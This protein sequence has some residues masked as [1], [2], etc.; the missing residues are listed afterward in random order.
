M[1]SNNVYSNAKVVNNNNGND[2]VEKYELGTFINNNTP[3]PVLDDREINGKTDPLLIE[4]RKLSTQLSALTNKVTNIEND[5]ISG[6]DIDAQVV[7]AIKDL[8]HYAAFFEQATFQ[9]EAKLLKTS[10]SIAQKIISIEVGENS[11]NMAKQTITHLLEKIKTASKVQIHLN[12]KDY[13]ILKDQLNLES[14]IELR[15]DANVSAGG[16]VIASD[17]GNFDGNIEAKVAS[18]LENLDMVI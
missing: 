14:F 9:M 12:P 4:I 17:L 2:N 5:G 16:V 3:K 7:Q 6:K 11:S 1:A 13:E 15:Q 18:M 10:I 8:K